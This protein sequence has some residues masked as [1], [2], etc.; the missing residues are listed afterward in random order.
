[1]KKKDLAQELGKEG[2]MYMVYGPPIP[3]QGG[4]VKPR[5]KHSL[6]QTKK[7]LAKAPTGWTKVG[8]WEGFEHELTQIKKKIYEKLSE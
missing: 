1:M 5:K 4:G 2:S 7:P 3:R 6:V 8:F